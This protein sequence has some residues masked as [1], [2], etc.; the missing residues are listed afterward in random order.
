MPNVAT[1]TETPSFN[2]GVSADATL[3][4]DVTV[5]TGTTATTVTF[6]LP[7]TGNGAQFNPN[8]P[9]AVTVS[10]AGGV[11]GD[12]NSGLPAAVGIQAVTLSATTITMKLVTNA[13]SNQTVASGTRFLF[14]Q[15]LGS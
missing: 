4:A 7:A 10:S 1:L 2:A 13:G 15:Q 11:S 3:A 9:I 12:S 6:G 5:D 8:L 14:T